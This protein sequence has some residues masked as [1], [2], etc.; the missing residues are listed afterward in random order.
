MTPPSPIALVSG[1]ERDEHGDAPSRGLYTLVAALFVVTHL[2]TD[3][4]AALLGLGHAERQVAWARGLAFFALCVAVGAPLLRE[5]RVVM[6]GAG[7]LLRRSLGLGAATFA[8][9]CALV[10]PSRGASGVTS[11][12]IQYARFARAP[13]SEPHSWFHKRLLLPALAWLVPSSHPR[14]FWAVAVVVALL[15]TVALV[16]LTESMLER[17]GADTARP[18]TRLPLHLALATCNPLVFAYQGP[19]YPETLGLAIVW[20]A[21]AFDLGAAARAAAVALALLAHEGLLFAVVPLAA[22]LLP[23]RARFAVLAVS[24]LYVCTW[25]TCSVGVMTTE[26]AR[27]LRPEGTNAWRWLVAYPERAAYGVFMAHKLAWLAL[28]LAAWLG[29]LGRGDAAR[30]GIVLLAPLAALPFTVDT[31]RLSGL[32]LTAV[33]VA[34]VALV[35][36][37]EGRAI[38]RRAAWAVVVAT[39]VV[40]STYV[41]LNAGEHVATGIYAVVRT[42]DLFAE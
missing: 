32:G 30:L 38:V 25:L 13:F 33:A 9:V 39:S 35:R 3:R 37:G 4:A 12:A 26:T 40:P 1:G 15:G 14:A 31:S 16:T 42:G 19:G 21:L 29:A 7:A 2:G 34:L 17:A 8:L 18:V 28:P 6:R 10:V 22:V 11:L 24:A 23:R 36:A 27:Q 5:L 41:G 20:I